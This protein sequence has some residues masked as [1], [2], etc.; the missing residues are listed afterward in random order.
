MPDAMQVLK[1]MPM[2]EDEKAARARADMSAAAARKDPTKAP[3][4]A[5]AIKEAKDAEMMKRMG[6]AYEKPNKFAK[7][8]S[9]GKASKRADGI[10]QR[11]KTKGRML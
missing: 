1:P 6:K 9:V 7:G 4:P 8:G 5:D 10:A 3:V 2:G 11:G